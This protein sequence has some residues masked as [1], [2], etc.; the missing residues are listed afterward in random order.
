MIFFLLSKPT[1]LKYEIILSPTAFVGGGL[2][3]SPPIFRSLLLWNE[4]SDGFK[5]FFIIELFNLWQNSPTKLGL[6]SII[7]PHHNH[8]HCHNLQYLSVRLFI[9]LMSVIKQIPSEQ[10]KINHPTLPPPCSSPPSPTPL[11]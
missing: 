3:W 4:T 6:K 8:P 10:F 2:K 1:S 11:S 7:S 5:I 9:C